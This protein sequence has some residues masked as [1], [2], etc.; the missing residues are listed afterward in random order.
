[1]IFLA[2]GTFWKS[3]A[4]RLITAIRV[5]ERREAFAE[6]FQVAVAFVD[7]C[8]F[9]GRVI[10]KAQGNSCVFFVRVIKEHTER[11]EETEQLDA[12]L[13]LSLL[14]YILKY[15][16]TRR[17]LILFK[18]AKKSNLGFHSYFLLSPSTCGVAAVHRK[19]S[20]KALE[21][22]K[23]NHPVIAPVLA[24]SLA[25]QESLVIS[26]LCGDTSS[27]GRVLRLRWNVAEVTPV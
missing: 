16:V 22:D 24:L 1:M 10:V 23:A 7:K 19:I 11:K 21:L 2:G 12:T 20:P 8:P 6:Q 15:P 3:S 13:L 27:Q 9:H 14:L 26:H 5:T 18:Q 25:G 17:H 4:S